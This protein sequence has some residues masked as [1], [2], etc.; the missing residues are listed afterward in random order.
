MTDEVWKEINGYPSYMISDKGR[1]KNCMRNKILKPMRQE[2]GYDQVGLYVNKVCR[3][4]YVHILVAEYFVDGWQPGFEVNHKDEVKHHNWK[5]N[6]EWCSSKYNLGYS[7]HKKF[8]E[9][10]LVSPDGEVCT[11]PSI[12]A[13]CN[14]YNLSRGCVSQLLNKNI[15]ETKGWRRHA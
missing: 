8:K 13:F 12:K 9:C 11:E 15:N 1:V 2:S 5:E 6:L 10:T 3:R 7:S 14:K 4:H